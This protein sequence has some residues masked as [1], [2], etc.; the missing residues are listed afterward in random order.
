[1]TDKNIASSAQKILTAATELFSRNYFSSVSIKEIAAVSGVNSALI[2]Y[3][4]GGKKNLYQEVLNTEAEVF[5]TLQDK[6]RMM[7]ITPLTKLRQYVLDISDSQTINPYSLHLV[8]RELLSPQPMFEGYVK[9]KLYRIHLFMTELVEQAINC[10]EI[11][12]KI[13]PTHVAFTLE[14]II[15][16]FFLTKKHVQTIGKFDP[17]GEYGYLQE[18]LDSYLASLSH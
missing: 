17:D 10:G 2:S 6:I 14:S 3:Y 11:T 4:F 18:A 1:M 15:M 7:N 9:N 8:Y 16:F 13:K 5:L 12:A